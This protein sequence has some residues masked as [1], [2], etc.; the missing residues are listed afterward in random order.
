MYGIDSLGF[1]KGNDSFNFIK[2]NNL[3]IIF[4]YAAIYPADGINEID[5]PIKLKKGFPFVTYDSMDIYVQITARV[6]VNSK[7]QI[8]VFDTSGYY[9]VYYSVFGIIE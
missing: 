7:L 4:G 9:G 1:V 8:R 5:L 2:I 3:G 6:L